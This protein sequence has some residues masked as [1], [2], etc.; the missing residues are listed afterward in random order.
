MTTYARVQDGAVAEIIIVDGDPPLAERYHPDIVA[1]CVALTEQQ[2]STVLPGY[3]YDGST[4]AAPVV[5]AVPEPT[6]AEIL[7]Q[8]KAKQ[9]ELEALLAKL[10]AT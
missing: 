10:P 8:I 2:A 6:E 1:A 5:P 7:A 4:F 9:A 3:T